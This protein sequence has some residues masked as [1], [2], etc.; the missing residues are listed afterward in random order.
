[1][2]VVGSLGDQA[3]QWD[4]LLDL[5]PRPSPF[6]RSWWLAAIEQATARYAL[7]TEGDALIGGVALE[8]D[9]R[10][11]VRRERLA[12]SG[13][14]APHNLDVV[15]VPGRDAEICGLLDRQPWHQPPWIGDFFGVGPESSLLR[16]APAS[17]RVDRL[18]GAPWLSL[19]SDF[20]A[21]LAARPKKLRQEIRR[22]ERRL[23]EAGYEYR[24]VDH[25]DSDRAFSTFE[26]LHRRRWGTGSHVLSELER[27]RLAVV[28][29]AARGE[30]A[31]Q[32][33]VVGGR[34]VATL[35]TL[36]VAGISSWYQ[37][38]REPDTRNVGTLL[39]ARAI[40]RSCRLGHRA[41]DLCV[42]EDPAKVRW[43]DTVVPVLRV[44]WSAG[45]VGRLTLGALAWLG[46]RLRSASR[47]SPVG[48]STPNRP[49]TARGFGQ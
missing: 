21:Y 43:A 5:A 8:T 32:E 44:R 31:F 29:G 48:A 20:D 6:L 11:G 49:P 36:E 24:A 16:Y 25:A 17:A 34:V 38:G 19:P 35:L 22:V 45:R 28:A 26:A 4:A 9:R 39:K 12:G 47:S 46:A 40:E 18:D 1:M 13:A 3:P 15:A 27:L 33:I 37:I 41:I 42:G 23:T 7:I 14:L 10:L 30:V 2:T